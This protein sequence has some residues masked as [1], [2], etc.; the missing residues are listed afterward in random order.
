MPREGVWVWGQRLG[1]ADGYDSSAVGGRPGNAP[2]GTPQGVESQSRGRGGARRWET[3]AS[4]PRGA[5]HDGLGPP[6]SPCCS[7]PPCPPPPLSV[8]VASFRSHFPPSYPTPLPLHRMQ[9][10]GL[11]SLVWGP[12]ALSAK[13]SAGRTLRSDHQRRAANMSLEVR[14][15]RHDT[16]AHL[17][18]CRCARRHTCHPTPP[19]PLFHSIRR[20]QRRPVHHTRW[21]TMRIGETAG[22]HRGSPPLGLYRQTQ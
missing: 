1:T 16:R 11:V 10:D 6:P 14:L 15:G 12:E 5:R 19:L 13:I 21:Y 2:Q 20:C 22:K 9:L 17:Y 4:A 7:S 8:R 18:Y 3:A